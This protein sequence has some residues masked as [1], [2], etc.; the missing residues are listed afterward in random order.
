MSVSTVVPL[1]GAAPY[2]VV[3]SDNVMA[4]RYRAPREFKRWKGAAMA[5]VKL[6]RK[7]KGAGAFIVSEDGCI[8]AESEFFEDL[9]DEGNGVVKV[10]FEKLHRLARAE[11]RR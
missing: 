7:W 10:E 6:T 9:E 1:D 4:S 5:L 2:T 11:R 8:L 3:Y